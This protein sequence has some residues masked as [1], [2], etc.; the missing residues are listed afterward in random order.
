MYV[1]MTYSEHFMF[2]YS[3]KYQQEL[4][5]NHIH[6]CVSYIQS[7][8]YNCGHLWLC[9]QTVDQWKTNIISVNLNM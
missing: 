6:T 3:N 8:L 1:G 4:D 9:T 7:I 2:L 5:N